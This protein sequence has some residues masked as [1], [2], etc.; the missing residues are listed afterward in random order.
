MKNLVS[1]QHGYK[2]KSIIL[3]IDDGT[4]FWPVVGDLL[5]NNCSS[6]KLYNQYR[7]Y[8]PYLP[9]LSLVLGHANTR[10]MAAGAS[11]HGIANVSSLFFMFGFGIDSSAACREMRV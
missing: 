7:G 5:H 3:T 11:A 6:D 2:A 8:R 10:T 9:I 4:G 1:L